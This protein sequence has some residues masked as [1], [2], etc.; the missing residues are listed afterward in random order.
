MTARPHDKQAG[1][2]RPSVERL[3]EIYEQEGLSDV[4][5]RCASAIEQREDRIDALVAELERLRDAQRLLHNLL[6][7][8]WD[9]LEAAEE[10]HRGHHEQE[11]REVEPREERLTLLLSLREALEDETLEAPYATASDVLAATLRFLADQHHR[12]LTNSRLHN[13]EHIA[14]FAECP[15]LPCRKAAAALR[16]A[17]RARAALASAQQERT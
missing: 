16:L 11:E 4:F 15:C 8:A 5:A 7:G 9:E 12:T 10:H 3:R 14:D 6:Q 13:P 2:R 17:E 1:E